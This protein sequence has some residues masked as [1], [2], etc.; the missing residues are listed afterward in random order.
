MEG[1]DGSSCVSG[2][3]YTLAKG[4]WVTRARGRP[5]GQ[6]GYSPGVKDR[7]SWVNTP[8]A[9]PPAG[10][11]RC[12]PL[13][14]CLLGMAPVAHRGNLLPNS[15]STGFLPFPGSALYILNSSS[16]DHHPNR[17]LALFPCCRVYFCR[18]PKS[19][20]LEWPVQGM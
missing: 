9:H 8:G 14:G 16:W 11:S 18:N 5:K 1:S 7:S 13:R 2:G 10:H 15:P 6:E 12:M 17:Q 3:G 20:R 19:G 4:A